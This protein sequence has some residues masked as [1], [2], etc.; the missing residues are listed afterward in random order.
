VAAAVLF[1]GG[2]T[3]AADSALD[4]GTARHMAW[5]FASFQAERLGSRLMA[6]IRIAELPAAAEQAGF[7]RSPRGNS[8]N[9]Q[10]PR[11]VKVSVFL[12]IELIG[13]GPVRLENHTWLDPRDGTPFFLVRTRTGL[14]DYY[15]QFRFTQEGVFRRQREPASTAEAARAMESWSRLR[16]RFYAFPVGGDRC[17]RV[18]ETSGLIYFLSAIVDKP[19]DP[20]PL[21]VF[22]KRQ[23]HR[24]SL[25]AGTIEPVAYDYLEKN[26]NAETRRNGTASTRKIRIESRPIGSYRGDVEDM[27]GKGAL[28][29]LSPDGRVPLIISGELPLIGRVDL[30][31]RE[32]HFN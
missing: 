21:C 14:D 24:V 25:L 9:P 7:L 27:F 1:L 6:D 17:H 19:G 8:V 13:R 2:G 12:R 20:D 22:H 10:W 18:L 4:V 3:E 31:L 26:G 16:E 15:Q 11:V 30:K 29:Y 23:L 32:G 28:L 5:S